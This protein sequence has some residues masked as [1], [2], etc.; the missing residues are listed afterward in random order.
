MVDNLKL[1]ILLPSLPPTHQVKRTDSKGSNNQQIPF[2]QNFKQKQKKKKE[3]D[4]KRVSEQVTASESD[5]LT[6]T[7][8]GKRRATKSNAAMNGK[9]IDSLGSRIIDIRV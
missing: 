7:S 8:S 9:S 6:G 5:N 1:N 4:P 3:D 2:N